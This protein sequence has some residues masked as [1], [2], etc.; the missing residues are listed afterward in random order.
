[1]P[2]FPQDYRASFHYLEDALA[3]ATIRERVPLLVLA[4][5]LFVGG[6]SFGYIRWLSGQVAADKSEV[7]HRIDGLS[8]PL[9]WGQ[10]VSASCP[11]AWRCMSTEMRPLA[12]IRR[13]KVLLKAAGFEFADPATPSTLEAYLGHAAVIVVAVPP[14]PRRVRE[15]FRHSSTTSVSISAPIVVRSSVPAL[16][17]DLGL[18]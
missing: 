18:L 10:D 17:I 8:V 6:G 13:A 12:V 11:R 16:L 4:S 9:G 15:R 5:V 7:R 14:P 3:F 2:I 1:M